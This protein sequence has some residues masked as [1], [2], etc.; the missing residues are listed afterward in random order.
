MGGIDTDVDGA[1]VMPGLYAA[2]EC[3]CVSVHGA[4]RLGGNS[5]LETI[6]FG[7]RAGAEVVRYLEGLSEKRPNARSADAALTQMEQKIDKLAAKTGTEDA[8]ALRA[9]MT[10]LMKEHFFL[11]R[12]RGTM[13][14][15]VDKLLSV[16]ERVKDIGLR[17][18]GSVFNV[19]MIRTVEFEGMVDL[20]LCVGMGA[21]V[22]EESRGAHYRTDFDK[23]D[24]KNW[25]KHTMAYYRRDEPG[26]RLDYK[27]VELGPFE[28]QERKY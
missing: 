10:A 14:A 23:R 27:P 2:G 22:R 3:A 19:D 17:W 24:D 6:V 26:P 28:L 1:T 5:L 15:G 25:L 21:L 20:A 12:E 11:F 16:K 8:Y 7:R 9:E 4:N 18:T 13:K